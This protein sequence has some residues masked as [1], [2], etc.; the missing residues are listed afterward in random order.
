MDNSTIPSMDNSTIPSVDNSTITSMYTYTVHSGDNS[1]IPSWD[2]SDIHSLETVYSSN[3]MRSV[4]SNITSMVLMSSPKISNGNIRQ[5][6]W[7]RI[8]NNKQDPKDL[9]RYN[10]NYNHWRKVKDK[11]AASVYAVQCNFILKSGYFP[12]DNCELYAWNTSD[13]EG[14]IYINIPTSNSHQFWNALERYRKRDSKGGGFFSDGIGVYFIVEMYENI[15]H[16]NSYHRVALHKLSATKFFD[17]NLDKA[18][19]GGVFKTFI[20]ALREYKHVGRTP[21]ALDKLTCITLISS[22]INPATNLRRNIKI[23]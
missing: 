15:T 23:C 5:Q 20:Y 13:I 6:I 11:W 19:I 18:T 1:Q 7:I 9:K 8:L 12:P 2:N 16:T 4:K 3:S 22:I 10:F 21:E 14:G 17:K